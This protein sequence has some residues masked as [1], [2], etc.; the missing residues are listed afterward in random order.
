MTEKKERRGALPISLDL[1]EALAKFQQIELEDVEITFDELELRLS[2]G[3]VMGAPRAVPGVP[4]AAVP[5]K[6]KPASLLEV[7]FE[8][9]VE[10]YPGQIVEVKLGATRT[11]GGTRGRSIV[12]GGERAPAFYSFMQPTPHRP[13]IAFDVF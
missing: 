11:E 4:P 12:I 13:V 2:P 10:E 3:V 9:P 6:V 8:V 7:E 5:A 1:L